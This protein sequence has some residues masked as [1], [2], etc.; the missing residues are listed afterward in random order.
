MSPS[1]PP[2]S[3]VLTVRGPA[4]VLAPAGAGRV[5]G[6]C[7]RRL[8]WPV[9]ASS[10]AARRVAC[11]AGFRWVSR[12]WSG[13]HPGA[14]APWCPPVVLVVVALSGPVSFWRLAGLLRRPSV[15]FRSRRTRLLLPRAGS[16]GAPPR[17]RSVGG[18]SS[19]AGVAR[20]LALLP[21][22]ARRSTWPVDA[23]RCRARR[24]AP[25]WRVPRLCGLW[26][27]RRVC[28]LLP[29]RGPRL[30]RLLSRSSAAALSVWRAPPAH[31]APSYASGRSRRP[32][33]LP[34]YSLS[35][36]VAA[37]SWRA[38]RRRAPAGSAWRCAAP[39]G[40]CGAVG[41]GWGRARLRRHVP[42]RV[43]DVTADRP[44]ASKLRAA[45]AAGAAR[46]ERAKSAAA[47][48]LG[49]ARKEPAPV[50]RRP[51]RSGRP[52]EQSV[53]RQPAKASGAPVW[54]KAASSAPGRGGGGAA[55]TGRPEEAVRVASRARV[56]GARA[57]PAGPGV[58]RA[59]AGGGRGPVG[60]ALARGR[61]AVGRGAGRRARGAGGAGGGGAGPV[62]GGGRVWCWAGVGG[63]GRG[64][65]GGGGGWGG[66]G[67]GGWGGGGWGGGGGGVRGGGVGGGGG[68]GGGGRGLGGG[69]GGWVSGGGGVGGGGG[70]GGGSW[71]WGGG[72]GFGEGCEGGVC[73]A[74]SCRG[75]RKGGCGCGG[76][77]RS[78]EGE[79]RARSVWEKEGANRKKTSVRGN[80]SQRGVRDSEITLA[81]GELQTPDQL[82]HLQP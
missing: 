19:C 57:A 71:G 75:C 44:A 22:R 42:R 24:V 68:G 77:E 58:L 54:V 7:L 52:G 5:A 33:V 65:G 59:A 13:P 3:P 11:F 66:V 23:R 79:R 62:L 80:R 55:G 31:A 48:N 47:W 51:T 4:L 64:G 35:R 76:S 39:G 26:R 32:R 81:S 14:L 27:R 29:R 82:S 69:W 73:V 45:R 25:V 78:R 28:L 1:L 70:G 16:A 6:S 20:A 67:G 41:P 9:V 74:W 2:V 17:G 49:G 21:A 30:G 34:G 37:A 72:V 61:G 18:H 10:R 15:L 43:T 36:G 63:G 38:F 40:A 8:R 12:R 53:A 46:A 60:R 50:A 56:R